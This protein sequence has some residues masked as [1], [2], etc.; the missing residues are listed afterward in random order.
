MNQVTNYSRK[1]KTFAIVL[2][3]GL[4]LSID[5]SLYAQWQGGGGRP[6]GGQP[7]NI[8]RFYGKV[9]DEEGKGVGFASVQLW[10]MKF[11]TLT[12]ERKD[13]LLAGQLTAENGDFSLE[14]LPVFGP[15]TLKISVLGYASYEQKVAFMEQGQGQ[16]GGSKK[17]DTDSGSD[18]DEPQGRPGGFSGGMGMGNF[19]KDLGNI[20]LTAES[21]T[22]DEVRIEGEATAVTLALD[23]KIFRVDKNATSVGGT[24]IDAL[25][26]VPSISVDIDGNMTLRNAP[27]QLF[28]DGRPTTLTLDQ[29]SADE[30]ESVEVITNPSAKYDASGGQAGIVN[31][32]LK[33]DRR[34]GY[35]GSVR[36]GIDTQM[37]FNGGGN[38]NAREGKFNV[39]LSANANRRRGVGTGETSRENL[40]GSPALNVLQKDVDDFTGTFIN[41]RGGVDWFMNNRNTITF[42]GSFTRGSFLRSSDIDISTD[43]VYPDKTV[44][45]LSRRISDSD[46]YFQNI[47][48][49][50]LFK[51]LFPKQGKE[52][53]ADINLNTVKSEGNGTFTNEYL[54]LNYE[55]LERQI[56]GGGSNFITIQTDYVEPI[57]KAMKVEAGLRASVRLYNSEN[58]SSIY[59]AAISDWVAVPNFADQY[60]FRDEVYAAYTTF[61]HQMPLWGYQLGLRVES[62]Q[63]TGDL[64]NENLTFENDYPFSFFPSLF[65]TRKINDLDNLQFSYSR[66]INRPSF[67]RLM[68]FTDFSD[69]LNLRRGNPNLL[70]EF[71]NSLEVSYQNIINKNHDFLVSVYY[72]QASDLITTFQTTEIINEREYLVT[73]YANSNSSLAYGMEF[74]VRNTLGKAIEL[75]SN[76]NLYNS[77]VD[78]S[79]VQAD[80]INEQFTWFVKENLNISLPANFKLQF[81]GQYQSKAAFTPSSGSGRFHGWGGVT[82]T[83]QGYTLPY[84]FVD[85]AL[86]K[87]LFKR[88]ASL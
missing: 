23:K 65:I 6:G 55:S 71:T 3:I 85:V 59:R 81:T 39:F 13:V 16:N 48:A 63:Y 35:N 2:I 64:P 49:S 10:G 68:P 19:D 37:G 38:V 83:A 34:I 51:H 76:V 60:E 73:S 47:G 8:G 79:N 21:V 46:R 17:S 53:T 84:W 80:L 5:S 56:N 58:E 25:Q 75:T 62:S 22:L 86:R 67:F 30:I 14:K 70:P 66:S 24:A 45:T 9:I 32:V 50:V 40:I 88:K 27:P 43:S 82:N 12:K 72:K 20:Q 54:T 31:I 69:S 78:A 33:K 7:M 87:D 11:D 42:S 15:M 18:S 57:N 1:L 26:N 74:T 36:G 44:T 77:R 41:L 52:L 28:V 61:S 29:I 4:G